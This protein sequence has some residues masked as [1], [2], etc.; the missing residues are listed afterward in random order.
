MRVETKVGIMVGVGV[1]IF[2]VLITGFGGFRIGERGYEITA[3]FNYVGGLDLNAPVRLAGME[4]GEV[5][6]M[7]IK[8]GKVHVTLYLRPDARL[9]EDSSITINSI[10]LIGEKYIEI[11]MGDP[12]KQLVCEGA[13]IE[14]TDPVSI[15]EVLTKAERITLKISEVVETLDRVLAGR[16]L[17]ERVESI[18]THLNTFSSTMEEIA[19]ENK[20]RVSDTIEGIVKTM[21][22]LSRVSERIEGAISSLDNVIEENKE[23]IN[24]A[25]ENFRLASEELR[26]T[27]A[28][29]K[30]R[31]FETT[32]D[33]KHIVEKWNSVTTSGEKKLDTTLNELHKA[34]EDLRSSLSSLKDLMEDIEA[35]QGTLG[36]LLKDDEM[37][38]DI[39]D[40]AQ[41]LKGLMEGLEAGEGALGKLLKDEGVA[42]D[43][44]DASRALKDLMEDLKAH[45]WKL[46]R[47]P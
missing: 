20:A 1:V 38:K 26:E 2:L 39:Q 4:I 14:G 27:T 7:E 19:V 44:E 43:I 18:L 40:A 24:K 8:D 21:D 5:R 13:V 36:R 16:G 10:G 45:P 25:S 41:A 15:S 28:G 35:G 42:K 37:A 3:T 6:D 11:S 47:K 30:R 9:R 31:L 33:L 22:D 32:T 46:L 12:T 23:D 17:K 29:L 34:T